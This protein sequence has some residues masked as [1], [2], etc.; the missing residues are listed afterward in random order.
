MTATPFTTLA[1][2]EAWI[3]AGKVAHGRRAFLATD[4]Y[5]QHY[6]AYRALWDA[7]K[8]ARDAIRAARKQAAVDRPANLQAYSLRQS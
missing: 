7:D 4:E 8:P 5:G 6:A 3:E 2:A 1:E